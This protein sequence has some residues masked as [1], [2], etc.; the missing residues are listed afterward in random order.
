MEISAQ[1][2]GDPCASENYRLT[3]F[4]PQPTRYPGKR[5]PAWVPWT[6]HP[7]KVRTQKKS[8]PSPAH[9]L[10]HHTTYLSGIG[11]LLSHQPGD[12]GAKCKAQSFPSFLTARHAERL[13]PERYHHCLSAGLGLPVYLPR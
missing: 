9:P 7:C 5:L 10:P 8:Y 6:G 12:S 11:R 13:H 4:R 2:A 1:A 3:S